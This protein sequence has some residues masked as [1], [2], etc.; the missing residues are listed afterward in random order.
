MEDGN[1]F[2]MICHL[3]HLSI[4]R[5]IENEVYHENQSNWKFLDVRE[6]L[7]CQY[8][9]VIV[10]I[11]AA[12]AS[13]NL[14]RLVEAMTRATMRLVLLWNNTMHPYAGA[15]QRY[16][17]NLKKKVAHELKV[18]HSNICLKCTIS[19][20]HLYNNNMLNTCRNTKSN[21]DLLYT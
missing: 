18:D 3:S 2:G 7:G 15:Y 11:D 5:R 1:A 14:C 8:P 13:L 21:I 17:A 9:V 19:Q 20:N 16:Y 6:A 4:R 12:S 10:I